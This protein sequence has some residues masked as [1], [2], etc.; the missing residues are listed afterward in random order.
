MN[1]CEPSFLVLRNSHCRTHW[2]VDVKA[3][4]VHHTILEVYGSLSGHWNDLWTSKL[5][6][7]WHRR[8]MLLDFQIH[9]SHFPDLEEEGDDK[10]NLGHFWKLGKIFSGFFWQLLRFSTFDNINVNYLRYI[11]RKKKK[12]YLYNFISHFKSSTWF[13]LNPIQ[14]NNKKRI[15]TTIN[16]EVMKV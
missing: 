9:F 12:Y 7:T 5:D 10:Q 15:T 4:F 16:R 3:H 6:N 8:N 1:L 14:N 2:N 13:D 11:M